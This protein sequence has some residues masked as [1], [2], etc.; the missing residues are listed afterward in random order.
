MNQTTP[1]LLFSVLLAMPLAAGCNVG[2]SDFGG[3]EDGAGQDEL[4]AIDPVGDVVCEEDP[5]AVYH[6][7]LDIVSLD[8]ESGSVIAHVRFNGNL[9]EW[10]AGWDDSLPFSLQIFTWN[11]TYIEAFYASK[12]T[13][14]VSD[15]KAEAT[16]EISG[17]TLTVTLE[18][19]EVENIETIRVSTFVYDFGN[20]DGSCDDELEIQV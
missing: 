1:Y 14:K 12:T 19:V 4:Q 15:G 8:V 10:Y 20:Y 7:E 2:G 3:N 18:G 11:G 17:D 6:E 13:M 16:G 9:E 5:G